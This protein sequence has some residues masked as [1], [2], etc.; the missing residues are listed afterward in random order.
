[1]TIET[2]SGAPSPS[3]PRNYTTGSVS[4]SLLV[5]A[6]LGT[7]VA[8]L[9]TVAYFRSQLSERM[10]DAPVLDLVLIVAGLPVAATAGSWL[11]AGREPHRMARRPIG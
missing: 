4:S 10:S 8:Y 5:G 6:A 9:A 11:L 3:Q 7:G 2:Q 1:M